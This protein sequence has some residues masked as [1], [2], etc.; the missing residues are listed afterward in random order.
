MS[1]SFELD[2]TYRELFLNSLSIDFS[3]RS[4]WVLIDTISR[5][6]DSAR[7]CENMVC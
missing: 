7:V 6:H 3:H 5:S 2:Q 4:F 1:E